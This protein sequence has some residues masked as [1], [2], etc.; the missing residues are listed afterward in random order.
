MLP[1]ES[2]DVC[3]IRYRASRLAN[4]INDLVQRRAWAHGVRRGFRVGV[5]IAADVD[6]ISLRGVQLR[7]DIRLTCR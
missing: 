1:T 5:V 7:N 3:T 4:G 2:D 6:R